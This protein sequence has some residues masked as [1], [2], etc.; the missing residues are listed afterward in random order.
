MGSATGDQDS[1]LTDRPPIDFDQPSAQKRRPR[2]DSVGLVPVDP[3]CA[4]GSVELTKLGQQEQGWLHPCMKFP[5]SRVP[6]NLISYIEEERD[7]LAMVRLFDEPE[8]MEEPF[9]STRC[10]ERVQERVQELQS[11]LI[12]A[13]IRTKGE[14]KTWQYPTTIAQVGKKDKSFA[15]TTYLD[16]MAGA[17]FISQSMLT[18]LEEQLG[19]PYQRTTGNT[20]YPATGPSVDSTLVRMA[21]SLGGKRYTED[22]HV[23]ALNCDAI[24]LGLPFLTKHNTVLTLGEKS[25]SCL[26]GDHQID[27]IPRDTR[28]WIATLAGEVLQT[29]WEKEAGGFLFASYPEHH[30]G[31]KHPLSTVQ[32]YPLTPKEKSQFDRLTKDFSDCY[33]EATFSKIQDIDPAT[34]ELT[35]DAK[36]FC[37]PAPKM[38]PAKLTFAEELI[39]KLLDRGLIEES[40]SA[41]GSPMLLVAKQDADGNPSGF[42]VCIDYRV[43]NQYTKKLGFPLPRID[44]LIHKLA[45]GRIF[46]GFDLESG[47][48][49]QTL[50]QES[51]DLTSFTTPMGMYRFKVLPMGITNGPALFSRFVSKVFASIQD[52]V[53]IYLDDIAFSSRT[54]QAHLENLRRFYTCCRAHG[55]K[56]KRAKSFTCAQRIHFLGHL[57]SHNS[58]AMMAR[59]TSKVLGRPRTKSELRT[60]LGILNYYRHFLCNYSVLAQPLY[61]FCSGSGDEH[62]DWDGAEG[63]IL[64]DMDPSGKTVGASPSQAWQRLIAEFERGRHLFS[65]S[66]SLAELRVRT[67][68]SSGIGAGGVLEAKV[69]DDY[70]DP[71]SDGKIPG[72]GSSSGWRPIEFFSC[73]WSSSQRRYPV[74]EQELLAIVMALQHWEHLLLGKKFT[75][76]TDNAAS[77]WYYTKDIAQLSDREARWMLYLSRWQPLQILHLPGKQNIGADLLSRMDNLSTLKIIDLYAGSCSMLRAIEQ[78]NSYIYKFDSIDYQAIEIDA[79]SRSTIWN[80]HQRLLIKGIPLTGNPFRLATLCEHD[81]TQLAQRVGR[82]DSRVYSSQCREEL[83]TA[84]LISGGP[85]CQPY[86]S[87]SKSARGE[88]DPRDGIP[89]VLSLAWTW[90]Q[91][92]LIENVPGL[93]DQPKVFTRLNETFGDAQNKQVMGPQRRRRLLWTNINDRRSQLQPLLEDLSTLHWTWQDCLD[94]AQGNAEA[95]DSYSPTMMAQMDTY[96]ER[97]KKAHVFDREK[98]QRPMIIEERECLAGLEPGDTLCY[99]RRKTHKANAEAIRRR[100]VGNA[101]PAHEYLYTLA[102]LVLD[103]SSKSPDSHLPLSLLPERTVNGRGSRRVDNREGKGTQV[104]EEQSSKS[105]SK[106]LI[107]STF[108]KRA[109]MG[110]F[111]KVKEEL[112]QIHKDQGHPSA[113]KL[114]KIY[115]MEKGLQPNNAIVEIAKEIV[116]HCDFCQ[117]NALLK[118]TRE[119]HVLPLPNAI[120]DDVEVDELFVPSSKE[121]LDLIINIVDR[122]SGFLISLP[123]KRTWTARKMAY[124]VW[125][126]LCRVG[127]PERIWCDPGTRFKTSFMNLISEKGVSL[128]EGTARR[129]TPQANVER[130]HRSLSWVLRSLLHEQSLVDEASVHDWPLFLQEA[131]L[132]LNN[133]PRERFQDF[134]PAEILM[135]RKLRYKEKASP[136][137]KAQ[138]ALWQRHT[139]DLVQLHH[140]SKIREAKLYNAANNLKPDKPIDVGSEVWVALSNEEKRKWDPS[141]VRGYFVVAHYPEQHKYVLKGPTSSQS[142]TRSRDE[143]RPVSKDKDDVRD[144]DMNSGDDEQRDIDVDVD[145]FVEEET[146]SG[147][148]TSGPRVPSLDQVEK[149]ISFSKDVK[150][151]DGPSKIPTRPE[152]MTT[153]DNVHKFYEGQHEEVCHACHKVTDGQ[154]LCCYSCP[155]VYHE[156]CSQ[157]DDQDRCPECVKDPAR[158]AYYDNPVG[159]PKHYLLLSGDH[160]WVLDDQAEAFWV[161]IDEDVRH[162]I[163]VYLDTGYLMAYV[164]RKPSQRLKD[165]RLKRWPYHIAGPDSNKLPTTGNIKKL[166]RAKKHN[167]IV[168]SIGSRFPL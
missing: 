91:A 154:L 111:E 61:R 128:I 88:L 167:E 55:I 145:V 58:I 42:R 108:S 94:Y 98:G 120:F 34:I 60:K 162:D 101:I 27:L 81:V 121:G 84:N 103:L 110:S 99:P 159:I 86:S 138:W 115:C 114:V 69:T 156:Q 125:N 8:E 96:S 168:Q 12:L 53:Q 57:I 135:G 26:I 95:P 31:E 143:I 24:I 165:S 158:G 109:M 148:E 118:H 40:N 157:L 63:E 70:F 124:E 18:K 44:A 32:D 78:L 142:I 85:P 161:E 19:A 141:Y 146:T 49:Q 150:G 129:H 75:L 82:P 9:H 54:V 107:F 122:Y 83:M 76:Y 104:M 45:R 139:K 4:S 105:K 113:R 14:L 56:L 47:F 164:N 112:L 65:W 119:R 100:L 48:Y 71:H 59:N 3:S 123:G 136:S 22:L 39:A 77:T 43:L 13:S 30:D 28:S 149:R 20:F 37:R 137:M 152:V 6:K 1:S 73:K 50:D 11:E 155:I 64:I 127:I 36:P 163:D 93:A 131:V 21:F 90:R 166:M 7:Y 41:W 97:D 126:A 102:S 10:H 117:S 17:S 130:A 67:D 23:L 25:K 132:I 80:I 79:H 2:K 51:R 29:S 16:S 68:A 92:Y 134:S 74:Q 46:A 15:V 72:Q 66:D 5:N 133:S 33:G 151:D 89:A 87:A 147:V 144:T 160:V 153:V 140:Q 35:S 38:G 62:L 116:A 106:A 52:F